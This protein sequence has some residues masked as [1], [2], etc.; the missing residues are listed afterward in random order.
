MSE[1]EDPYAERKRLTFEQAEG[2]AQL[3]P[4]SPLTKWVSREAMSK[5]RDENDQVWRG[6]GGDENRDKDL[7]ST[8][9]AG[10]EQD[11]KAPAARGGFPRGSDPDQQAHQQ[12]E[13]VPGNM[14]QITLVDVLPASQ[15]CPAHPAPVQDVSEG[16][17]D[18]LGPFAQGL[19]A[20]LGAQP[21]A[22]VIDCPARLLVPM[23]ARETRALGF[24]DP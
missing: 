16:A 4:N 9:S 19:L 24:G 22:I 15:P 17:L 5:P 2:A 23:P 20:D 7:V 10:R 1:T 12:P 3:K 11:K 6:P 13:I 8:P 14:D 18:H 21:D